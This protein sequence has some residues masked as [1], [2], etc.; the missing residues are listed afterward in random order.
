MAENEI[1]V[2]M[3]ATLSVGSDAYAYYVNEILEY[4]RKGEPTKVRIIRATVEPSNKIYGW[5]VS[6]FEDVC[7]DAFSMIIKKTRKSKRFGIIWT[8]DG[9]QNGSRVN[10][11]YALEYR[12][13]SF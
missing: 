3:P 13:P 2:G 12:D 7:K 5:I 8:T 1:Y 4:D 11:G 10:L 9:T 6:P